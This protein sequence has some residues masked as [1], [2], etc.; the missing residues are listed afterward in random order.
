MSPVPGLLSSGKIVMCNKTEGSGVQG[1]QGSGVVQ[2]ELGPREHR[3]MER[4]TN[5]VSA[6]FHPSLQTSSSL[7]CT[8]SEQLWLRY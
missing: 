8:V 2:I 5:L 3:A 1:W 7:S 4:G 6:T